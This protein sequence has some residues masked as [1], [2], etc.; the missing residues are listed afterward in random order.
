[1][2]RVITKAPIIGIMEAEVWEFGVKNGQELGCLA[3]E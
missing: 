3:K 2:A 1:V